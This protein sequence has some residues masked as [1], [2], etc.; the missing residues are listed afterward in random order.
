MSDRL[1]PVS[2]LVLW[3]AD[4]DVARFSRSSLVSSPFNL[5]LEGFV[6]SPP[7]FHP[8]SMSLLIRNFIYIPENVTKPL[9]P[10]LK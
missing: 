8:S 4:L 2:S 5:P 9:Q 6:L 10:K 7:S 3:R 1:Y